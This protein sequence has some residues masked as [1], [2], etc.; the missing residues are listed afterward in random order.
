[1]TF[2]MTR[3]ILLLATFLSASAAGTGAQELEDLVEE[4]ERDEEEIR[5]IPG[6][7]TPGLRPQRRDGDRDLPEGEMLSR[8]RISQDRAIDPDA[9]TVGP[10]DGLQLYIWGEFD[11][12]IPFEVGPEGYALVPTVGFFRVSERS[13]SDVRNEI[14]AAA[15][16]KYPGLEITL[17]L[18][19]MRFFNVYLTGAIVGGEGQYTVTPIT[20]VSDLM[21][22]AGGFL[23]DVSGTEEVRTASGGKVTR[24]IAATK[25]PTGRRSIR[26]VHLDGTTQL[27][28]LAMFLATGDLSHNPYVHMGDAI[29]V[30]YQQHL[31]HVYGSVNEEGPQEFRAG[32]TVG[33]LLRLAGGLQGTAPLESVEIWRLAAASDSLTVIPLIGVDRRDVTISDIS[34]VSLVADDM[35][36]VRTRSDWHQTP[37]VHAHGEMA[38]TGRY[39]IVEGV[40]RLS[41]FIADAGGFTDNANLVEARV[42]RAKQ[43]AIP[44]PEVIR[45]R[46]AVQAGGYADLTPE[47]RAYLKTKERE[48]RGRLAVD[49][50]GLFLRGDESQD[51]LLEGGDVVFVPGKRLTVSMSGQLQRPGL[52]DF[53]AGRR[54]GFYLDQA[55]G[56]SFDADKGGARLIRAR[57]G[58]REDLDRNLLVEPGDEIWVPEKEYRDW[59]AIVQSVMRSTA[60]ALTLILLVRAI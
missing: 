58:L 10:G 56:Y 39:R 42:I 18:R 8:L 60:E 29:H 31:V 25:R 54:V 49:F 33:D 30:G 55:G 51:V 7:E 19:S 52:V 9:Y 44:D 27:V 24:R 57:T 50:E 15:A 14:I 45:L 48:E 4:S 40:T 11:E 37:T 28:D 26:V 3:T 16:T 47:E 2:T 13:L 17:T 12:N 43:R 21:E 32:D 35:L 59:I 41:A 46:T 1:M 34:D 38:Y 20:R 22:L 23:D 53:E 36:F 6:T 5:R